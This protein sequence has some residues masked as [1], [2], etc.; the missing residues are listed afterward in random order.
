[1][2]WVFSRSPKVVNE[3]KMRR[4]TSTTVCICTRGKGEMCTRK[5]A[6]KGHVQDC[7]IGCTHSSTIT[8]RIA[9][10]KGNLKPDNCTTRLK[11]RHGGQSQR[12][13]FGLFETQASNSCTSYLRRFRW[14]VSVGRGRGGLLSR[15]RLCSSTSRRGVIRLEQLRPHKRSKQQNEREY[16]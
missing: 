10:T 7:A 11:A 4:R 15:G 3:V 1:M 14:G 13:A 16:N 12:L 9:L 2:V 8:T 6:V 5:T